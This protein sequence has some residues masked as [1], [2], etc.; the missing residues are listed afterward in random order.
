MSQILAILQ[1]C[2]QC[3][4]TISDA[5][6]L[7]HVKHNQ[8]W[9]IK[10]M[11]TTRSR[12]S[13]SGKGRYMKPGN[14]RS[15]APKGVVEPSCSINEALEVSTLVDFT[16]R[17]KFWAAENEGFYTYCSINCFSSCLQNNDQTTT[18][19]NQLWFCRTWALWAK[20]HR[21]NLSKVQKEANFGPFD[22]CTKIL[23][24]FQANFQDGRV[25]PFV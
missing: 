19:T 25:C 4:W 11:K 10:V 17:L 13:A 12:F 16:D 23:P 22:F 7:L 14:S 15:L 2:A 3:F 8:C 1:S 5:S 21:K 24:S 6:Y 18:F 20:T 9:K